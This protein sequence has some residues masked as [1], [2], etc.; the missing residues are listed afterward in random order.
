MFERNRVDNRTAMSIAVELTFVDGSTLAGKAAL[1]PTRGI[2]QLLDGNETFLF[3]EVFGGESQFVPKA[4]IKGVKL[5]P[6]VR[7]GTLSLVPPDAAHFDPFQILGVAKTA[8]GDEVRAA[9]LKMAKQYH[10]DRFAGVDLPQE[11]TRYMEN[12]V[13]QVYAAF[14]ALKAQAQAAKAAESGATMAKAG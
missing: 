6:Q 4:T 1:P 10:P 2:H 5:I 3:I 9:Y 13:R 8:T 11:V 12:M 14:R 7:P